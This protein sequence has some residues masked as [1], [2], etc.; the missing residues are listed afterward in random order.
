MPTHPVRPAARAASL[1]RRSGLRQFPDA[2]DDDLLAAIF[3]RMWALAS[4]RVLPRNVRPDELSEEE[5]IAFWADD[6]SRA[7]GRHAARMPGYDE[8][9]TALAYL[10][11]NGASVGGGQVCPVLALDIAGFTRPDRDE[12]VRIYLR[13]ILYEI[14]RE[15]LE[16][17]GI[18]WDWCHHEDRGDGAVVIAPPDIP[19]HGIVNPLPERLRDLIRL[20]NRMSCPAARIQ[21]RAAAH[22]GHVY[23]DDHG[24]VGDDINLLFRMLDA[25]PLRAAL[26]GSG[27]ELALAI[28]RDMYDNVVRRH[29][30]LTSPALFQQMNARVKGTRVNAWIHVP[31]A[32]RLPFSHERET[33]A[34]LDERKTSALRPRACRLR[35]AADRRGR[36]PSPART[37]SPARPPGSRWRR[38]AR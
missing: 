35:S 23:R 29:P 14:L 5:L 34:V 32:P 20:H 31:G 24:L 27:A 8:E 28:S 7:A 38:P 33:P 18:P 9:N 3:V 12:E 19:A 1:A 36:A 17:S 10:L 22:I 2:A 25:R 13:K 37:S 11:D 16:V 21:V 6:P 26:A 15:A 4:G 30:A